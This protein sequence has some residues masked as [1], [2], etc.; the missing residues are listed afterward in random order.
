[1]QVFYIIEQNCGLSKVL[2]GETRDANS[3]S[4]LSRCL[5][6]DQF[7]ATFHAGGH[8]FKRLKHENDS[9]AGRTR[10]EERDG[11]S[12]AVD[13]PPPFLQPGSSRGPQPTTSPVGPRL[14]TKQHKTST[15]GPERTTALWLSCQNDIPAPTLRKPGILATLTA[16]LFV[17]KSA[18]SGILQCRRMRGRGQ[19][20]GFSTRTL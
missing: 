6:V 13:A 14:A 17:T 10:R 18:F 11:T 20:G 1:M 12:G 4:M 2:V 19:A 5:L 16:S 8:R 15:V 7:S 3:S 9:R